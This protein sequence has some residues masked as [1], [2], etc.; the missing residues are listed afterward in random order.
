MCQPGAEIVHGTARRPREPALRTWHFEHL[1]HV[2]APEQEERMASYEIERPLSVLCLDDAEAVQACRLS[3]CRT[4][5]TQD[6][7]SVIGEP[8]STSASPMLSNHC[9]HPRCEAR[10]GVDG[11][12]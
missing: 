12:L 7:P 10:G 11:P 9:G 5:T 8:R 1:D 3:A 6:V 4:V 2:I